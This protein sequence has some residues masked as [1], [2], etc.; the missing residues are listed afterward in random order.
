MTA[1]LRAYQRSGAWLSIYHWHP[2]LLRP[3]MH[4]VP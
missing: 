1:L 4:L 3:S 2:R